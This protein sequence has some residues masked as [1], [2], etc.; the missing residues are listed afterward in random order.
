MKSLTLC[1]NIVFFGFTIFVMMTDGPP[2]SVFYIIFTVL[3][4]LTP[5]LSML[6]I[7]HS[8][9]RIDQPLGNVSAAEQNKSIEVYAGRRMPEIGASILNLL[10][11][12]TDLWVLFEQYP[13]PRETGFYIF[14]ALMLLTPVLNLLVLTNILAKK[15]CLRNLIVKPGNNNPA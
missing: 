14:A 2:D 1:C 8:R 11:L 3:L 9:N 7:L 13:H 6:V 10:L 4:L 12:G 5:L 15:S